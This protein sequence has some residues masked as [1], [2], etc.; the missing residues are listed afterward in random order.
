MQ[1]LLVYFWDKNISVYSNMSLS[2]FLDWLQ[3]LLK[4]KGLRERKEEGEEKEHQNKQQ[5]LICCICTEM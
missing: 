2:S 3:F 4:F 5:N 1:L